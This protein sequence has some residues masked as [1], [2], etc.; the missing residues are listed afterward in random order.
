M[1]LPKNRAAK[2][3]SR[4]SNLT[5]K[6]EDEAAAR[7]L[8]QLKSSD[9]SEYILC[10]SGQQQ[11][12]VNVDGDRLTTTA[13]QFP[14]LDGN[15]TDDEGDGEDEQKDKE[16]Q[17]KSTVDGS[18]RGLSENSTVVPKTMSAPTRHSIQSL[19]FEADDDKD[20]SQSA[21][22]AA[23]VRVALVSSNSLTANAP[24]TSISRDNSVPVEEPLELV[25][26]HNLQQQDSGIAVDLSN[27]A[28][29]KREEDE[30]SAY[31]FQE[32]VVLNLS[33]KKKQIYDVCQPTNEAETGA[34]EIS[35]EDY[36]TMSAVKDDRP[37]TITVQSQ[38]PSS[39]TLPPPPLQSETNEESVVCCLEK[40]KSITAPFSVSSP[41]HSPS[42]PVSNAAT[43]PLSVSSVNV[44]D[45]SQ[46]KDV[47]DVTR[48]ESSILDPRSSEK[49]VDAGRADR[50]GISKEE[51][52][53]VSSV[54]KCDSERRER[55][56]TGVEGDRS[57]GDLSQ[58]TLGKSSSDTVHK[59]N[60]ASDSVVGEHNDRS[61]A[62]E[63]QCGKHGMMSRERGAEDAVAPGHHDVP[64]LSDEVASLEGKTE[65]LK[66]NPLTSQVRNQYRA[67][68]QSAIVVTASLYVSCIFVPIGSAIGC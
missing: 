38:V 68:I 21:S 58:P 36:R 29:N 25:K 2:E 5:D 40:K 18:L 66:D 54:E 14:N 15:V 56:E 46:E 51:E 34:T 50:G 26:R 35:S 39:D 28:R 67:C 60:D 22:E 19:L 12:L 53:G 3:K 33:T 4:R 17:T 16:E 61:A 52:K 37:A 8:L 43:L 62:D 42:A 24:S 65:E 47:T 59:K 63:E 7:E 48:K 57:S 41:V 9:S 13:I 31:M 20:S 1:P 27:F 45:K 64:S 10:E 32:G 11:I 49:L 44:C 30:S 6:A 23:P 55:S